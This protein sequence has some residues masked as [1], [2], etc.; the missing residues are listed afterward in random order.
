VTKL[1]CDRCGNEIL[2]G[3]AYTI[4]STLISSESGLPVQLLPYKGETHHFCEDCFLCITRP[5]EDQ[6][7]L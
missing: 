4:T 6:A 3:F 5:I 2:K 7:K 1:F